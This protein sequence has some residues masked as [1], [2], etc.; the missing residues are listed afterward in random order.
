MANLYTY[1]SANIRRTW[2][3]FFVFFMVVVAIGY[4]FSMAY[5]D[6]SFVVFALIFSVVYSLISYYSSAAI[7]LSLARAQPIEK[8][9]N[10]M[11]YDIVENLAITAG[12]PMPAVYITPEMQINAFATGR[13]PQHAAIAVTQGAL[14]RLN[15]TELQGVVAHE[16]SHVGNRDILVSTVA[17]VLAGVIS[18]IADIFLRSFFWSGMGGRNRNNSEAGEIF[19]IAAII[20]SILAPIGTM[21]IQLA[22]SRRREALADAS[23]VLLTRYPEGLISALQKIAVDETP[24]RS[25][26]DSTAHLWLDNPFKGSGTS[27]WHRLFMTH[28]PIEERIA[29]LKAIEG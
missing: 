4:V 13:D 27:W 22:I 20:L 1:Q 11:L 28:P 25:A 29:A 8:S 15:K 14:T 7:A 23:G 19:F 21:L 12:L 24:M 17:A 9:D 18:L 26:K 2:V 16:L 3:L 6:P 5:N 10:P